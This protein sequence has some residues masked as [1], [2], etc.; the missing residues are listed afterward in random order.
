MVN[1]KELKQQWLALPAV[2]LG[3]DAVVA[4]YVPPDLLRVADML[5]ALLSG[6]AR[7]QW[8]LRPRGAAPA[9]PEYVNHK[10]EFDF[11]ACERSIGLPRG[12]SRRRRPKAP[13]V[14]MRKDARSAGSG[15]LTWAMQAANYEWLLHALVPRLLA[16]MRRAAEAQ[17]RQAECDSDTAPEKHYVYRNV[18][19]SERILWCLRRHPQLGRAFWAPGAASLPAAPILYVPWHPHDDAAARCAAAPSGGAPGRYPLTLPLPSA[20]HPDHTGVGRDRAAW[21]RSVVGIGGDREDAV[22]CSNEHLAAYAASLL[23]RVHGNG[24]AD[25]PSAWADWARRLGQRALCEWIAAF[26]RGRR[27]L[28]Q[29]AFKGR[30]LG[31]VRRDFIVWSP[32]EHPDRWHWEPVPVGGDADRRVADLARRQAII[33]MAAYEP[34]HS[35]ICGHLDNG[36]QI[37]KLRGTQLTPGAMERGRLPTVDV[38]DD[39]MSE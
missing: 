39:P 27:A 6:V 38:G 14:I 34:L 9:R 11:Y 13:H 35:L 15:A 22:A 36:H 2:H 12:A 32:A 20:P 19:K 23:Y 25:A 29:H 18:G 17:D 31:R 26:A 28:A 4:R 3:A 10:W 33:R 8:E 37:V 21:N 1:P 16:R 5:A 7:V 30:F 24:S